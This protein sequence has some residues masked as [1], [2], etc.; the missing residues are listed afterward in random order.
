MGYGS[1]SLDDMMHEVYAVNQD[2]GWTSVTRT[3]GD[4]IALLMTELGEAYDAFREHGLEY[5]RKLAYNRT[6]GYHHGGKRI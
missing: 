1:K 5:N 2:N 4:D 6:R 3:F